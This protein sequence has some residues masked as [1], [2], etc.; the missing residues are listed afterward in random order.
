MASLFNKQ[1]EKYAVARPT[2][3]AELFDF[4]ASKTPRHDLVWDVGTGSGQAAVHVGIFLYP[5]SAL[6]S[7][8]NP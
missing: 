6:F 3:P 5:F 7:F 4:I 1:A 2:Y 8:L